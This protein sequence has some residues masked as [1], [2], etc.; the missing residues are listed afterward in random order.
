[1]DASRAQ[2]PKTERDLFLEAIDRPTPGERTAF[3]DEACA[4]E[5]SLRAAVEALLLHHKEDGFLETSAF[6]LP[7]GA[8]HSETAPPVVV[9][10]FLYV[11]GMGGDIACLQA[12]DGKIVWRHSLTGHFGGRVPMWSYHESPLVDGNKVICTPGGPDAILVAIDKSSGKTIWKSKLPEAADAGSGRARGGRG[13]SGGAAYASAIAI[14]FDGQ[15]QYVQLTAKTLVGIAASDG[16][17]LWRY[18]RPS[19]GMGINCSTPVY[20]DGMVFAASAYGAGGGLVKL[21]K[22]GSGGIKAEEVYSTKRM[23]NHHGGMIVVDGCLYGANGGNE[24]GHLICLDF[25]TGNVLWDE[26]EKGDGGVR[27]GSVTLADGRLYY[28]TEDGT[29]LLIEPSSKQ[30]IERGRFDPPDRSKQPAWTHPV[31]AN[32]KLY[33]RDQ[34]VL[35]CYDV[36]AK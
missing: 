24:G 27:K 21:Q 17:F 29:M 15:R 26:R 9:G 16:K 8:D 18:D 22:D 19:N 11:L 14:D 6:V 2:P 36:K 28:R 31:I 3:L 12:K 5:P 35:L 4:H 10:G 13:G 20:S 33:V 25:K 23:Q 7:P 1:M 30:Y 34:D 32:G